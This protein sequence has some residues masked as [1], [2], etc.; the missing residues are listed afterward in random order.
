M[1]AHAWTALNKS[2][3]FHFVSEVE[4]NSS[5]GVRL[6][7]RCREASGRRPA[8]TSRSTT[9]GVQDKKTQRGFSFP[10][11][12]SKG[13]GTGVEIS[14]EQNQESVATPPSLFSA[15]V[16][17]RLKTDMRTSLHTVSSTTP[18]HRRSSALCRVLD[19]RAIRSSASLA[20]ASLLLSLAACMR[21]DGCIAVGMRT[22]GVK[23]GRVGLRGHRWQARRQRE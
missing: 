8:V 16:C 22:T 4:E 17:F 9:L 15:I 2:W 19:H 6:R 18:S 5:V 23:R 20:A 3:H 13:T 11:V 7:R 10:H 12:Q 14:R 1:K 21:S